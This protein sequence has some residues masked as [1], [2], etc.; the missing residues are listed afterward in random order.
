[1]QNPCN[2]RRNIGRSWHWPN[3]AKSL[4][5]SNNFNFTAAAAPSDCTGCMGFACQK[6]SCSKQS[7]EEGLRCSADFYHQRELLD[8]IFKNSSEFVMHVSAV[9]FAHFTQ[10]PLRSYFSSHVSPPGGKKF[11]I[12]IF[13]NSS[14]FVEHV[15]AVDFAHFTQSPLRSYFSSH[16]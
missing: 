6:S 2:H 9:D 3:K 5:N 13:K 14:D 1:M 10:P 4:F 7:I 11:F 16:V 8:R 15:S 12:R